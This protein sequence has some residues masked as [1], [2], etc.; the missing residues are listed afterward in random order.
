MVRHRLDAVNDFAR[1]GYNLR[2]TC[3]VCEHAVDASAVELMA[4]L[5]RRQQPLLIDALEPR[6]KCSACGWR[7]ATIRPVPREF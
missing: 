1:Q 5:H 3:R 4:E 2:I 6:L 7:G